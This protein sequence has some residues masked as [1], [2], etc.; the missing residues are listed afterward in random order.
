M[1]RRVRWTDDT[2]ALVKKLT[3]ENVP[4]DE[5]ARRFGCS[6]GSLRV[7]CSK[8]KVSLRTPNWQE[9]QRNRLKAAWSTVAVFNDRPI[10]PPVEA[11]PVVPVLPVHA[12]V[13]R[14][15]RPKPLKPFKPLPLS[16][17]TLSL[18]RQRADMLG[19]TETALATRLLEAIV[20]NDLYDTVLHTS[21]AQA[22]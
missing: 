17:V 7:N 16:R 10:E 13:S 22:A 6:L 1:M 19:L 18:L 8:K 12:V 11:P 20:Q 3:A 9:R 4:S 14:Q 21:T 2:F 15:F 5:I